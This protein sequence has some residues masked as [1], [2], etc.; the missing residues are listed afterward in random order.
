M[1]M[2]GLL[3]AFGAFFGAIFRFAL[4]KFI[5]RIYPVR[6]PVATLLINVLG[7]FLLGVMIGIGAGSSWRL[8]LGTGFMGAFTTFSTFNLE[9][10]QLHAERQ[11]KMLFTYLGLSYGFGIGMAF[12]G[13][14]L[15]TYCAS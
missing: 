13:I 2:D 6:L 15:G 9:N 3:I 8:L 1:V 11:W 14:V 10:I 12:I 7:S 4:S 5:K